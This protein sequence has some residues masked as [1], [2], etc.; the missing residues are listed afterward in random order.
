MRT[1]EDG[2]RF[3]QTDPAVAGE[4]RQFPATVAEPEDTAPPIDYFYYCTKPI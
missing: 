3:P 4:T 2:R 1:P